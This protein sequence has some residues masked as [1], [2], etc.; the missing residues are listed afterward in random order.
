MKTK[1]AAVLVFFFFFFSGLVPQSS[2]AMPSLVHFSMN[3]LALDLCI[4]CGQN[5]ARAS[6]HM[7]VET[8]NLYALR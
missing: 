4:S 8:T 2:Q 6:N 5:H 1:T 7:Y 3:N